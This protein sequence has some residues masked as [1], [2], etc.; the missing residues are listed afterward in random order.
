MIS[1]N[2]PCCGS[3]SNESCGWPRGTVTATLS[4]I[5][6]ILSFLLAAGLMVGLLLSNKVSEAIAVLGMV[7]TVVSA[8]TT[9]YF[10]KSATKT[11][12]EAK[13]SE[14]RRLEQVNERMLSRRISRNRRNSLQDPVI[15]VE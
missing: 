5:I 1:N 4:I 10:D 9:H 3:L 12:T 8:V 14:I 6:I 7:F 2:M 11:L 13:D 15:I